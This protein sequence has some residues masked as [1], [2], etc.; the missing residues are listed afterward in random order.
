MRLLRYEREEG[1]EEKRL[2]R[3]EK[4]EKGKEDEGK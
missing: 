4:R 3:I 1:G 2:R